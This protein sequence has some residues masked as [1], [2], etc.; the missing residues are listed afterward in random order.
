MPIKPYEFTTSADLVAQ[1]QAKIEE[2]RMSPDPA[3]QKMA[4]TQQFL[5][6]MFK[7]P[8][9]RQAQKMEGV[10]SAASQ[11]A[12]EEGEDELDYQIRQQE[13]I[14]TNSAQIDP[15]VAVQANENLRS[16]MTEKREQSKL[17]TQSE[18]D[19]KLFNQKVAKFEDENTPVI[20]K[21]N[22]LTGQWTPVEIGKYGDDPAAWQKRADEMT[23]AATNGE[24]YAVGNKS[25]VLNREKAPDEE[26]S[27]T[28]NIGKQEARKYRATVTNQQEALHAGLPF[29]KQVAAMP[30]VMQGAMM[31]D[32]GVIENG[33]V[34]AAFTKIEQIGQKAQQALKGTG[35]ENVFYDSAGNPHDLSQFV[36]AKLREAGISSSVAEARVIN[37]AYAAARAKDPGGRLSDQDVSLALRGLIGTGGAREIA[38]LFGDMARTAKNQVDNIVALTANDPGVINRKTQDRFNKTHS[39]FMSALAEV[40]AAADEL[41]Q[42]M[43]GGEETEEQRKLQDQEKFNS[44]MSSKWGF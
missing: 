42:P 1:S 6:S 29:V 41:G 22:K 24:I 21:Y 26:E 10:M 27:V 25:E 35:L 33:E 3:V 14:R 16:L 38:I 39:D 23:A 28:G 12:K 17:K 9:I 5:D 15:N 4:H 44:D 32:K 20:E 40:H 36:S 19:T 31:N 30:R 8:A 11:L 34:N 13:Y 43:T 37:L 7:L 2:M 18:R